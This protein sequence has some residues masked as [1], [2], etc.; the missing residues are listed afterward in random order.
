MKHVCSGK[1]KLDL[2]KKAVGLFYSGDGGGGVGGDGGGWVK[3][4]RGDICTA[5]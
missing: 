4:G 1:Q 5:P 3:N 2:C